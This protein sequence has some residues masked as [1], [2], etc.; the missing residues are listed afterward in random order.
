MDK[1]IS[2]LIDECHSVANLA[3]GGC[4]AQTYAALTPLLEK[5]TNLHPLMSDDFIPTLNPIIKSLLE[6]QAIG[7][8]IK[9]SDF[10]DFEM[11]YILKNFQKA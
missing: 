11:V 7:D 2:L 4:P 9:I 10:L 1:R 5:I 8:L 3:K 6:A